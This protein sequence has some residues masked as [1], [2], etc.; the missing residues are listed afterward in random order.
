MVKD[1]DGFQERQAF[2]EGMKSQ[3]EKSLNYSDEN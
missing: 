2:S 3:N 1:T